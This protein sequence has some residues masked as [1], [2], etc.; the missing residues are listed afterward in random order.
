MNEKQ[1]KLFT[2]CIVA[3]GDQVLLG[4][5]KRGFGEGKWNGFGGKVGDGETVEA[6]ARREL[7]EECGLIAQVLEHRAQFEFVS[8]ADPTVLRVHVFFV[9]G[10]EGELRETEEMRP[11]WFSHDE[12]PFGEMWA[13]DI[14]WLPRFLKGERLRGTFYFDDLDDPDAELLDFTLETV[15][16]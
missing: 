10:Y 14:Y 15:A 3:D 4:M 13:D 12:I 9:D 16:G 6:A 2:L 7:E 8:D 5:K 11:K 1:V